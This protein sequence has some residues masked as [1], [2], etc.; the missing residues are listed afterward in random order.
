MFAN[1]KNIDTLQQLFAEL[2]NYVS[3]QAEY[4][5]LQLVQKLTVLLSTLILVF[6]LLILGIMALFYLS[7]TLAYV[8]A[9]AVGGLTASYGLITAF[10]LLLIV[11]IAV[12]RQQLIVRP[13]VRF[14][15]N[16]FLNDP[17]SANSSNKED[18]A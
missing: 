8:M 17:V 18:K 1:D 5:S 9:P 4:F 10:I 3:L 11:V 15:A 16:L 7:F 14:L 2:K 6:V 13:L 12:F